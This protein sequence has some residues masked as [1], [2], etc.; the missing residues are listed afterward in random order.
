MEGISGCRLAKYFEK[1][2]ESFLSVIERTCVNDVGRVKYI[3]QSYYFLHPGPLRWYTFYR[4]QM[5]EN[6]YLIV[7]SE[8]SLSDFLTI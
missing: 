8:N 4:F 3:Q 7:N 5:M 1:V 2:E 6:F